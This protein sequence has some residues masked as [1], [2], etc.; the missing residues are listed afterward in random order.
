MRCLAALALVAALAG[1]VSRPPLTPSAPTPAGR[2]PPAARE[3]VPV[4]IHEAP[5]R[6]P[7]WTGDRDLI[8]MEA[9]AQ[10][11]KPYRYG[12]NGPDAFDCSGLVRHA[13][14]AGGVETPRTTATLFTSGESIEARDAEPGDLFF[15]RIDH[16]RAGPSHVVVYLGDGQGIHAP[17]SGGAIRAV[18]L[19][20]PYFAQRYVGAR[21]LLR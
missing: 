12:G 5:A 19:N 16:R 11:G 21:R 14:R 15:Y 13:Y 18:N 2:P 10:V 17:S 4:A 20:L 9:F 6:Q 3:R 8:V 1:C 7:L